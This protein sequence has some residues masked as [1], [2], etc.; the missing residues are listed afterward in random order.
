MIYFHKED[1]KYQIREVTKIKQVVS[2]LVENEQFTLGL[3][4][5]IICSDS[6][7]LQVNRDYLDH[8]YYTDII[9]FDN[10]EK[11]RHIEGDL[12]ISIDTVRTNAKLFGVKLQDELKRV[13]LHGVLHLCG[14]NDK[15]DEEKKLMRLKENE[16]LAY[17]CD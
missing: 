12:F 6:Y 4:N 17:F 2:Q 5:L 11:R 14:Y 1:T 10:A 8:D 13:I 7:I 3:L 15:T 16:Y 9:T